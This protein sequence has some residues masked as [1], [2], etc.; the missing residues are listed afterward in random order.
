VLVVEAMAQAGAVLLLSELQ[1]RQNQ[2]AVFTGIER[3]RFRRPVG[4]GDQ[5]RLEVEVLVWRHSAGR[6][7]GIAS[8]ADKRVAEAI[9]TCQVVGRPSSTA[10]GSTAATE[11]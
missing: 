10:A 1:D 5:L 4:P 3:A 2:L 9:I 6:M 8:V 7:Q 11:S